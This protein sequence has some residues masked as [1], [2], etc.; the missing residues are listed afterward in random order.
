M[1]LLCGSRVNGQ[2]IDELRT[3]GVQF[4]EVTQATDGSW[5]NSDAVGITGLVT[6]SLLLSGKGV[7][8]A[9]VKKGLEF[10]VS[11][12]QTTGGI[13]TATSRHQ[14]YETCIAILALS[15]A[16]A[17]GRFND[18]IKNAETFCEVSS[19]TK[20]KALNRLTERS[21]VAARQQTAPGHVEYTVPD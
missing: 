19:G 18:V 20:A 4:L 13:H 7:D 2:S 15:E 6:T 1:A 10:I 9:I 8:D 14:N 21:A 12:Q 5:T 11:K 17:D 3:K 16:N